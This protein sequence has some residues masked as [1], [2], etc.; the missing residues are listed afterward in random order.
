MDQKEIFLN[1]LHQGELM[2]NIKAPWFQRYFEL[3]FLKGYASCPHLE[4]IIIHRPDCLEI[5]SGGEQKQLTSEIDH[6]LWNS[7]VSYL[8]IK[9]RQPFHLNLPFVSFML[10]LDNRPLRASF[11][12]QASLPGPY[13]KGFFRFLQEEYFSLH[14]FST[15][16]DFIL[17]DVE[18]KKNILISGATGSGKTS[19]LKTLFH[20]SSQT[21]NHLITIEDTHELRH[22]YSWVSSLV[23]KDHPEYSMEKYLTYAMRMRPER[24]IL[25]EIRSR[26]VVPLLMALNCGHNGMLA[27]VHANS[28]VDALHRLGT[29]FQV[30]NSESLSHQTV[31]SLLCHNIDCVIHMEDKKIT[32]VIK[33][34]GNDEDRPIFDF[35]VRKGQDSVVKCS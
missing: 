34:L 19:L 28:A 3:Q 27:T 17:K 10:S 32:E 7:V 18:S 35:V 4:E 12:H 33:V 20:H 30:Y 15:G 13:H 6:E 16:V 31:M 14:Q 1:K 11:I 9:H 8:C 22:R 29:L 5:I 26:E 23:T 24:I 21:K 2:E 25:G